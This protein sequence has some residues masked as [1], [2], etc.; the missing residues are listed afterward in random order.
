MSSQ[1]ETEF[2]EYTVQHGGIGPAPGSEE[3]RKQGC[4]CPGKRGEFD[5]WRRPGGYTVNETCVVHGRAARTAHLNEVRL[6]MAKREVHICELEGSTPDLPTLKALWKYSGAVY[7]IPIEIGGKLVAR[8]PQVFMVE[9]EG[10]AILELPRESISMLSSSNQTIVEIN[11]LIRFKVPIETLIQALE[12]QTVPPQKTEGLTLEEWYS[13]DPNFYLVHHNRD[14]MRIVAWA[15][16]HTDRF[17]SL[18]PFIVDVWDNKEG[19]VYYD[20]YGGPDQPEQPQFLSDWPDHWKWR[21][22]DDPPKEWEEPP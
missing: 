10:G 11:Q 14:H 1:P 18:L 2:P 12:D 9:I 15:K 20:V 21:L 22:P 6:E 8:S 5:K 19:D 4:M 13:Q 16:T 17:G 7:P 3:A